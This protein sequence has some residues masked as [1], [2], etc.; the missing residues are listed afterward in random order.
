MRRTR[1]IYV[2]L[3]LLACAAGALV[4]APATLARSSNLKLHA[5]SSAPHS[6]LVNV[7]VKGFDAAPA[8]QV[9]IILPLGGYSCGRT[10]IDEYNH[11]VNPGYA[12]IAKKVS[13]TTGKSF[14]TS[15]KIYG[16]AQSKTVVCGYLI[17][18]KK[19]KT[20]AH[21]KVSWTNT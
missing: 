13:L 3:A 18:R 10:Y 20:Y 12:A 1:V 17:N 19:K 11:A 6:S 21:A 2:P 7:T 4:V 9:V 16:G 5:P 14:S 15:V 8:N